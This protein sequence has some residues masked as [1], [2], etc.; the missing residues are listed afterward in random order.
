MEQNSSLIEE[1]P[2]VIEV[3][4]ILIGADGFHLVRQWSKKNEHLVDAHFILVPE[5]GVEPAHLTA[6]P[7]EDSVSTISPLGQGCKC[8]YFEWL[9]IKVQHY[10]IGQETA[11]TD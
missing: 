9:V 6:L 3:L 1:T 7:P 2:L 11:G 5:T 8:N 4:F 10:F